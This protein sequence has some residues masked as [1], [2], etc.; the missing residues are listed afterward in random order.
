MRDNR[1]LTYSKH[2]VAVIEAETNSIGKENVMERLAATREVKF[3]KLWADLMSQLAE[4]NQVVHDR[5]KYRLILVCV[6]F[7]QNF[8][9]KLEVITR[10][11]NRFYERGNEGNAS[12]RSKH[13]ARHSSLS[14]RH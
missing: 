4:L 10:E 14:I 5:W 12:I 2:I 11:C 8:I 1:S 3:N 6:S 13:E 7:V 9:E